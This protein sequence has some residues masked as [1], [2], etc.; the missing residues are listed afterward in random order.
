MRLYLL[1]IDMSR[2]SIPQWN[3]RNKTRAVLRLERTMN[4]LCH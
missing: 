2:P 1:T 3:A 4:V